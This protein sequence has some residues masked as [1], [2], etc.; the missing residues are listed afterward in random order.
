MTQI[1]YQLCLVLLT[2]GA[3]PLL[4]DDGIFFGL[5]SSRYGQTAC[6]RSSPWGQW[7]CQSLLTE[8]PS[9]YPHQNHLSHTHACTEIARLSFH[10]AKAEM[11][12]ID[13]PWP[14][15]KRHVKTNRHS[16]H[17]QDTLVARNPS[18][19]SNAQLSKEPSCHIKTANDHRPQNCSKENGQHTN[20]M[21]VFIKGIVH[22]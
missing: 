3:W 10:Q 5:T 9:P 14:F 1:G 2:T 20:N 8:Q 4:R 12:H 7:V 16:L 15:H 6:D 13:M 21:L 19:T 11:R 18:E 22:E 17:W